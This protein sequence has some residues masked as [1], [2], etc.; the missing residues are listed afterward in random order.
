M[1]S[2]L[3]TESSLINKGYSLDLKFRFATQTDVAPVVALVNR[4][5]RGHNSVLGWT[6]E[7]HLLEGERLS[8]KQLGMQLQDADALM[9]LAEK[10]NVLKGCM[11]L[12]HSAE[13][14]YL[15][16]FAVSPEVQGKGVGRAM[17]QQ[18]EVIA[19]QQWGVQRLE[20]VVISQRQDLIAYYQRRG[21]FL[22][23]DETDF[24][25]DLEVGIPKKER[26]TL[27]TLVKLL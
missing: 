22:S 25:L 3:V 23:G 11:M 18:A 8:S 16:T 21:Y 15:G 14:T 5:Y 10:G 9:L 17:L 26:L 27:T 1:Y 6:H 13:K 20:M 2:M 12:S 19:G 24:P 4:A 7:A